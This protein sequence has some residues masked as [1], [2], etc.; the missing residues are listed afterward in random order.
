MLI[1][2]KV[3]LKISIFTTNISSLMKKFLLV[4]LAAYGFSNL[5]SQV[6]NFTDDCESYNVGDYVAL[7]NSK[8]TTWDVKPGTA[9]DAMISD[10]KAHG[11]TK[12]IKLESV[13]PD[14]GPTDLILPFA[15]ATTD[16]GNLEFEM[17]MYVVG[18]TAAYFNFQGDKPV[19]TTWVLDVFFNDDLSFNINT[20]GNSIALA[21]GTYAQDE[22]FKFS[23]KIDLTNNKWVIYIND[24]EVV[25]FNNKVNKIYGMDL[26][27]LN[28][29]GTSTY[30][31]D[32][33]KYKFTPAVLNANDAAILSSANK[34][35][36]LSGQQVNLA[37]N[38]RNVGT[39]TLNSFDVNFN[40]GTGLKTVPFTNQNIASKATKV[41]ALP[42]K[43]TIG[44]GASEVTAYLSNVNGGLD[45]NTSND[46][47]KSTT[48]GYVPATGKKVLVEEGTG[49][50]CPWCPRGAV[51][52][53]SMSRTYPDHFIG[54]A[55]HN[56]DP[57]AVLEYDAAFSPLLTGYPNIV[58]MRKLLGDPSAIEVPSLTDLTV[59]PNSVSVNTTNYDTTTRELKI[60]ISTKFNN[61]VPAGYTLNCVITEDGVKG[62]TSGYA[63][64]NNYAGGTNGVMG[65]YELLPSTVPANRMVYDHVA[66]AILGP[67][68]GSP[69]SFPDVISAGDEY[70]YEYTYKIPAGYNPA[71]MHVI[72]FVLNENSEIDNA[73]TVSLLGGI[74]N[75]CKVIIN[76][77]D[78]LA[79]NTNVSLY[80]NPISDE[81][82]IHFT[83]NS[84]YNVDLKISDVTGRVLSRQNFGKLTG[85]QSL[86]IG[87]NTLTPGYYIAELRIGNETKSLPFTIK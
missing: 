47:I 35:F 64:K 28:P 1:L 63:Q 71:K 38:V 2:R 62:T 17:Y 41:I 74:S 48:F 33:V 65:G 72:S 14:G 32:D 70:Q 52:M 36:G 6:V 50:W 51:Y 58:I 42:S 37:L 86:K 15:A 82:K 44:A 57:M 73:S 30:Y 19:G 67:F 53:D 9:T 43:I 54:I 68:N 85:T 8:W 69:N 12:S 66:R 4:F 22:W 20:N 55:V 59:A 27:P 21:E 39:M 76:V 26:F 3:F 80:P 87:A 31:I 25:S 77:E 60:C 45:L 61:A 29:N 49:T 56:N 23:T 16:I 24:K 18:G 11:G 79:K 46:S 83:L 13:T 10:E 75:D 81:S 84:T 7:K 40:D 5:N 34:S 78:V